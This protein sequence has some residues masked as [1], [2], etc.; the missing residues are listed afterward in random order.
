M[1]TMSDVTVSTRPPQTVQTPQDVTRA[2]WLGREALISGTQSTVALIQ[3]ESKVAHAFVAGLQNLASANEIPDVPGDISISHYASVPKDEATRIDHIKMPFPI[4]PRQRAVSYWLVMGK[5]RSEIATILGIR[6]HTV[7]DHIK[8]IYAKAVDSGAN[9]NNKVE[10]ANLF[11]KH[12]PELVAAMVPMVR[13]PAKLNFEQKLML[14]LVSLG[15]TDPD[16]AMTVNQV[17]SPAKP[18]TPTAV[19]DYLKRF[20]ARLVRDGYDV[21]CRQQ[22]AL[23]VG[24]AMVQPVEFVNVVAPLARATHQASLLLHTFNA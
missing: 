24:R 2:E 18:K 6:P 14:Q 23:A 17:L 8:E 7:G 21:Y 12:N 4:T 15:K 20:M 22:L 16:I 5:T 1:A 19:A 3:S 9:V 13:L 10:F 11:A